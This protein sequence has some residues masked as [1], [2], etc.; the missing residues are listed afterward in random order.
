MY[1]II[2][3]YCLSKN[4]NTSTYKDYNYQRSNPIDIK[5]GSVS[6]SI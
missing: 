2:K 1:I 5:F 4:E 3:F 6:V